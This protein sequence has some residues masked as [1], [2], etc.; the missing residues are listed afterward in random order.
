MIDFEN[1]EEKFK[2]TVAT[3]SWKSLVENFLQS[4]RIYLIG[5]GGLHFTAA[6]G[7][8]DCTRLIPDKL[9]MSFDS[10]GYITSCANDHGYENLFIRWLETSGS[11]DTPKDSMVIGLSCSG[12]SKNIT[13]ALSWARASGYK[14]SMITGQPSKRL[15]KGINEVS[16]DCK[17]FHTCEV[18][19]LILFYQLVHE[20][21]NECPEILDEIKRKDPWALGKN[22][23]S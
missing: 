1:I 15:E 5:N 7:A 20:A 2:Q 21:G 4:N 17:Y 6:H 14:T 8:T 12:N 16:L 19:T 23:K 18:L 22:E 9:V 10:N 13:R 3:K 11:T